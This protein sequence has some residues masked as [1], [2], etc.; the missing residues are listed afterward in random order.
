MPACV[1]AF[2]HVCR[3][4]CHGD[5]CPGRVKSCQAEERRMPLLR[6]HTVPVSP[7]GLR[8]AINALLINGSVCLCVSGGSV[9]TIVPKGY[10]HDG[11]KTIWDFFCLPGNKDLHQYTE[12]HKVLS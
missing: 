3:G 7:Q 6:T 2:L 1:C 12:S 8:S 9:P 5:I 11:H 4:Q 10:S